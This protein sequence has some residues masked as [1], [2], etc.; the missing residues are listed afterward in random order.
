MHKGQKYYNYYYYLLSGVEILNIMILLN[1]PFFF[2]GD[3]ISQVST[4]K[5]T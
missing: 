1:S 5:Y 3:P 4:R 2:L